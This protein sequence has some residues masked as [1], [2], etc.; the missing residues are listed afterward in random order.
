MREDGI[1]IL[2]PKEVVFQEH[3]GEGECRECIF[4]KLI[5]LNPLLLD[6]E[7]DENNFAGTIPDILQYKT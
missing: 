1:T 3:I 2:C 5:L 6:N 4:T 7:L